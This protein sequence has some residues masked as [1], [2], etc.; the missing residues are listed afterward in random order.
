MRNYKA[1]L[2]EAV[3][4]LTDFRCGYCGKQS[5]ALLQI[6]HVDPDGDDSLDNYMAACRSCNAAKGRKSLEEYRE[7]CAAIKVRD[8]VLDSS[9]NTP[10][11][12]AKQIA[13]ICLQPWSPFCLPDHVFHFEAIKK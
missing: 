12:N 4:R 7:Y 2:R 9:I 8:R 1:A 6:D 13:W 3:C 11:F 5:D 10:S